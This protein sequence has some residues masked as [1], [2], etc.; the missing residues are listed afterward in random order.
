[1]SISES[2]LGG[3]ATTDQDAYD[4][5]DSYFGYD[6]YGDSQPVNQNYNTASYNPGGAGWYDLWGRNIDGLTN[7]LFDAPQD[8]GGTVSDIQSIGT[9][10]PS[11]GWL[12]DAIAGLAEGK[13]VGWE[14][15]T[16]G[17]LH[18]KAPIDVNQIDFNQMPQG[19]RDNISGIINPTGQQVA[20]MHA[21]AAQGEQTAANSTPG[22]MDQIKGFRSDV[23]D[24]QKGNREAVKGFFTEGAKNWEADNKVV[25]QPTPTGTLPNNPNLVQSNLEKYNS[26]NLGPGRDGNTGPQGP[27]GTSFSPGRWSPYEDLAAQGPSEIQASSDAYPGNTAGLIQL[28]PSKMYASRNTGQMTD[29]ITPEEREIETRRRGNL[30]NAQAVAE[31]NR[32]PNASTISETGY[33]AYGKPGV[34][35]AFGVP[36]GQAQDYHR[37]V[38]SDEDLNDISL[39]KTASELYPEEHQNITKE[40]IYPKDEYPHMYNKPYTGGSNKMGNPDP[41][42]GKAS[43]PTIDHEVSNWTKGEE[44]KVGLNMLSPEHEKQFEMLAMSVGPAGVVNAAKTIFG[45]AW[46]TYGKPYVSQFLA[47]TFGNPNKGVIGDKINRSG[48]YLGQHGVQDIKMNQ[49]NPVMR[50]KTGIGKHRTE[51]GDTFTRGVDRNIMPHGQAINTTTKGYKEAP[52]RGEN[53][54][55]FNRKANIGDGTLTTSAK[56]NLQN[57]ARNQVTPG[58][59]FVKGKSKDVGAKFDQGYVNSRVKG[60]GRQADTFQ[61]RIAQQN[62]AVAKKNA[63]ATYVKSFNEAEKVFKA[64]LGVED[65]PKDVV[66]KYL[67]SRGI[68]KPK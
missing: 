60:K 64:Q 41:Y 68:S 62:K 28:D 46:D 53:L 8:S 23:K 14:N 66:V 52:I 65:V 18:N 7:N 36:M 25:N 63:N 12:G 38:Y 30:T 50:D 33:E 4:E 56:A 2:D 11:A 47:K 5:I 27:D 43:A 35:T 37:P 32:R 13:G 1:M 3:F 31:M 45:K 16:T 44:A 40:S 15:P 55:D 67:K 58:Y 19:I 51:T 22:I 29:A 26:L 49:F 21:K 20:E 24:W 57:T 17:E 59:T 48:E 61:N 39:Y 9:G 10:F 54:F 42:T 34:V 6:D